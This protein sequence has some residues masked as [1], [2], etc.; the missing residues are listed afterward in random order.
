MK[1]LLLMT[2]SCGGVNTHI[3]VLYFIIYFI[4]MAAVFLNTFIDVNTSG[5]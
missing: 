4:H 5:F 3:A 1:V 2:G